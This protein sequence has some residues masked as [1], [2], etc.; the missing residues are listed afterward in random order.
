MK[1]TSQGMSI[2]AHEV[3]E[4]E[5]GALQHAD[6]QQVAA[7][8]V[9]RDLPRRAS[10]TRCSS[11][12]G[13]TRISPIWGS[14]MRRG[15]LGVER[16]SGGVRATRSDAVA[17]PRRGRRRR[18]RAA[19]SSR[20]RGRRRARGGARA[21]AAG[22]RPR[23]GA[24]A[25]SRAERGRQRREVVAARSWSRP[26]ERRVDHLVEHRGLLAQQLARCAGRCLGARG[27]DRPQRRHR[28]PRARARA[29]RSVR[30]GGVLAPR[31]GR[32]PRTS[33]R[34]LLARDAPPAAAAR[35]SRASRLHPQQRAAP[36]RG[37]EPVE[38]RLDLVGGGVRRRPAARR[39]AG[40]PRAGARSARRAPRPGRCRASGGGARA[41][42]SSVDAEPLA[43]R[44][45]V[46]LV[47]AAPRRA[48]R[49]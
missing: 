22:R 40:E 31:A 29:R 19:P 41:S 24:A 46:R 45:A 3:G 28:A 44:P 43:Q 21:Q 1:S 15:R 34:G 11:S 30:V 49:S 35:A 5:D 36:G 10:R 48:A 39:V 8:V 33:A 20:A 6:E 13:W 25:T 37:R 4:E 16:G 38:D 26:R 23:P 27:C 9:A 12:S 42:T 18:G 14:R 7:L 17:R 2:C 32:A 47:G